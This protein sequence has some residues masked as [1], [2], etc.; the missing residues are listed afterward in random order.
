VTTSEHPEDL[1]SILESAA[2]ETSPPTSV[3][4]KST[5]L[6]LAAMLFAVAM[7]FIDQTI[8]AIAAPSIQ[9][10]LSLSRSGEQ[11]VINA[12]LLALAAAFALGGRLADVLGHRRMVL[13]GI[14]GFASSSALCGA[15]PKGSLAETWMIFFRVVQGISGAIMIPAALAIVIAAFPIQERG[16]A[17]AI[18]FGVSGGLTSIG[19]IAGGFLTQWTWRAIFWI[20]VPVAILALVL[21]LMAD[22]PPSRRRERID[23]RGAALVAV[24]MGLSVLGFEQAPTWGWRNPGTWLCI[25]AGLVVLAWFVRVEAQ[26]ASPLI[27]VRI[28][29]DRAFVVDNLVLFFATMA[30][31]PVF[32]FAS[33][34]SQ[35]SL[36]Y[37]ANSAGLYLLLFFAGFAP[38]AQIGGRMLDRAG[39]KR[40]MLLGCALATVG[41]AL[42]ASKL[43]DLNLGAQWPFIVMSGAGLG[44]LLGPASTDAVNRSINASYGEVTGITQTVRNYA[45]TLGIAVLGTVLTTVLTSNLTTSL[46]KL[47]VPARIARSVAKGSA[48]GGPTSSGGAA[49]ARLQAQINGA[50][51][52]DFA[53]ATRA[54]LI[55][56]AIALGIAFLCARFHPGSSVVD[57]EPVGP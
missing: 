34:Y 47:G 2:E 14:V 5:Y 39:A 54:V 43:T 36:G 40:P 26:T 11:W 52:H 29:L 22:I 13:I 4:H 25:V 38:A 3:V 27:K 18:F 6:A 37:D 46:T 50:V 32:F 28:F 57:A 42:W 49:P 30:F 15:C 1:G 7:T 53:L 8:V 51:A 16:R 41:F 19:P 33:V 9:S 24:G 56:M 21:T 17:M 31:I 44:L 55:G 48:Q 45:S 35:V 23:Y 12:Y 20:N 10:Q